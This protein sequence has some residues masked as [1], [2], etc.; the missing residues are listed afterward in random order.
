MGKLAKG[1]H[2]IFVFILFCFN[3]KTE[4]QINRDPF[5][6]PFNN[7]LLPEFANCFT[8]MLKNHVGVGLVSLLLQGRNA[9]NT[10]R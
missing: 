1:R 2:K 5:F 7:L 10:D 9:N 6:I 4:K 8:L 3:L